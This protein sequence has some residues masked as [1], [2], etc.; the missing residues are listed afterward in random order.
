MGR[1]KENFMAGSGGVVG[2]GRCGVLLVLALRGLLGGWVAQDVESVVR[3]VFVGDA[4]D[5]LGLEFEITFELGVDEV[6]VAVEALRQ[7][8][9]PS[10]IELHW[11]HA[12]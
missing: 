9:M 7:S 3:E 10:L 5:V 12:I 8:C 2:Y 4:L 11:L 1:R 6:G